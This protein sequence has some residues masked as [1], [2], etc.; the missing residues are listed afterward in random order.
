MT[1][2]RKVLVTSAPPKCLVGNRIAHHLVRQVN[3]G[4]PLQL[5]LG[6]VVHREARAEV[7]DSRGFQWILTLL[8]FEV[9]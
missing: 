3:A 1:L 6:E 5:G 4:G 2:R 9:L 8:L 7:L